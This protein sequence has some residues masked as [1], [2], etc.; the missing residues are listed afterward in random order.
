MNYNEYTW[1]FDKKTAPSVSSSPPLNSSDPWATAPST[2]IDCLGQNCCYEGTNY[3]ANLNKCVPN[4]YVEPTTSTTANSA[5]T[6]ANSAKTNVS[7][8]N[9]YSSSGIVQGGFGGL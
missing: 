8:L 2:S 9:S 5:A 4:S 1:G 3:N 7:M 6:T